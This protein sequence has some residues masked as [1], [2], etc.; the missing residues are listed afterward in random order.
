MGEFIC[1]ECGSKREGESLMM[2]KIQGNNSND[3]W[4]LVLQQIECLDCKSILPTH[5]A[6]RW[7]GVS[8]EEA[9]DERLKKYKKNNQKQRI[10][11]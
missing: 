7:N 1:I 5:L 4:S 8:F 3:P 10:N 9:K 11:K 2:E 6:E